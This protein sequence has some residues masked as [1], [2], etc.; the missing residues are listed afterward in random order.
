MPSSSEPTMTSNTSAVL[1][2]PWQIELYTLQ[3]IIKAIEIYCL[4]GVKVAVNF[5]T[6]TEL[7]RRYGITAK[8]YRV[9]YH[10]LIEY[11]NTRCEELQKELDAKNGPV[12]N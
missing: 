6:V 12:T 1:D 8:T 9:A 10:Q 7:R 2:Q 11:H 4:K 3:T 5:P